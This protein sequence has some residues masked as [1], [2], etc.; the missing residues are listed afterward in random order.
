[1]RT[2]TEKNIPWRKRYFQ[3]TSYKTTTESCCHPNLKALFFKLMFA[4]SFLTNTR[5]YAKKSFV[6]DRDGVINHDYGYVHKKKNFHFIE[7]IFD[8]VSYAVKRG[9]EIVVVTNQ[10]GIAHGFYTERDFNGINLLDER[11]F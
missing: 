8:L 2:W 4:V 10:A 3:C 1:M 9:Y 6:L 7:G 5:F 11:C